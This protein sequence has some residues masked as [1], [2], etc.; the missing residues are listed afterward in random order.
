MN[1]KPDIETKLIDP[2]AVT[3]RWSVLEVKDA[4]GGDFFWLKVVE[5]TYE[6]K[7]HP[8]VDDTIIV[9]AGP[10]PEKD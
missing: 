1:D 2:A 10:E 5:I 3:P 7:V 6:P 4:E 9:V 8:E